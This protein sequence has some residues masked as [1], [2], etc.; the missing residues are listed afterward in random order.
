MTLTTLDEF[1]ELKRTRTA[2]PEF[3]DAP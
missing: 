2:R 3:G 1:W